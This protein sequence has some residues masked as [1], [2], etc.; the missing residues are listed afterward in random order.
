MCTEEASPPTPPTLE[1]LLTPKGL[2]QLPVMDIEEYLVLGR[3]IGLM[4]Q[5][6]QWAIGDFLIA[7]EQQYGE[8]YAQAIDLFD[9]SY[10]RLKNYVYVCRAFPTEKSRQRDCS[11]S[12]YEEFAP[13]ANKDPVRAEQLL[14][15]AEAAGA[16]RTEAKHIKSTEYEDT[17]PKPATWLVCPACGHTDERSEFRKEIR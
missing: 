7:G 16:T 8:M 10:D 14:A 12:V 13:V 5:G 6:I 3:T 2:R 9:L 11:F 4:R 15:I 17:L 1:G